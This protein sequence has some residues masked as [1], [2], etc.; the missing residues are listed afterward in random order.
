[1]TPSLRVRLGALQPAGK[2]ILEECGV[3][4]LLRK[5]L[6]QPAGPELASQVHRP[7][8]HFFLACPKGFGWRWG[9]MCRCVRN[10]KSHNTQYYHIPAGLLGVPSG[11]AV[12]NTPAMQKPAGWGRSPGRGYGNPLQYS[13]LENPMDREAWRATVHRVGKSRTRLKRLNL[14]APVLLN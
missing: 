1:M 14:H 10:Y 9:R 6:L 11:S 7:A 4:P 8:S 3:G 13:F 12:K 5:R 2:L